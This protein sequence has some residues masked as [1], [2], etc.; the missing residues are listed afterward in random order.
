MQRKAISPAQAIAVL[1]LG[2]LVSHGFG[3]SLA[4]AMLPRMAEDLA[5]GYGALGSALAAG[6]VAYATGALSA[7]HILDRIPTRGL[8][9][10]T[11]AVSAAGLMIVAAATSVFTLAI[12]VIVTGFI[13]PV[14]WAVTLHVAGSTSPRSKRGMVMASASGGAAL[15]VLVNGILV[16]TSD[17]LHTWRVS[18]VIAALVAMAPVAAARFV[19]GDPIAGPVATGDRVGFAAVLRSKT[20]RLIVIA[21]SVAGL[22]GF[23]FSSFLT[24]TAVDEMGVSALGAAALWWIVGVVGMAGGPLVGGYADR[25]SPPRAL[26]AVAVAYMVGL[27]VLAVLWS[28]PGLAVAVVGF[29][30]LNYPIWGL[31][32]S[33]I[34]DEID[35]RLA[36]RA[37]SLGLA[38]AAVTGAFGN[39]LAGAWLEA[40]LSFRVPIVVILVIVVGLTLWLRVGIRVTSVS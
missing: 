20:G 40:T 18:F 25:R 35:S 19:Y 17:S 29:A 32:G 12:G 37:I 14:S 8:L 39:A 36:V 30:L 1:G 5:A 11:Y 2:T 7:A 6:L 23:P 28:Y 33:A 26:L 22:V 38:G 31:L 13:A 3:L 34:G 21:S 9:M 15:G 4:P 27:L 10:I 16:Q 24:A